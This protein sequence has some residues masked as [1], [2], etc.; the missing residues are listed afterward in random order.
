L[1]FFG[2]KWVLRVKELSRKKIGAILRRVKFSAR[3]F[4]N[5][6][7][8]ILAVV[9]FFAGQLPAASKTPKAA[10][11]LSDRFELLPLTRSWQ[12]QL[13]VRAR[14]NG[15][16]AVLMVDSGAPATLISLKR[17]SD[18]HL[19]GVAANSGLP[20]S[21]LVNG[22]A[23]KLAIVHSLRLGALNIV[24]MPV[25]LTDVGSPQRVAKMVREEAI[26]GILG[27]DVLFAT[28]AVMDCQ[29]QVLIL[30]RYP[31]VGGIENA[32]DLRGYHKTPIFVSEGYNLFVNSSINGTRTKL[33]V[34][35]GAVVTTLHLP[36]VRQL[37]I[38]HYE[39]SITSSGVNRREDA[40]QVARVQ[41]LS[42]GSVDVFG[43]AIGVADLRWLLPESRSPKAHPVGG[44]LGAELLKSHHGIIDFGSRTLYLKG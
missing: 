13:L 11:P 34:D 21:V 29:D 1:R 32:L 15:K 9:L 17:R 31:E 3:G 40:V 18:F 44:L 30:N 35:T 10:P 38:P 26:D 36:F 4:G 7:W 25:V 23:D 20:T 33:L 28:K 41:K 2:A 19:E 42:V 43:K 39:T 27:V 5:A 22:V 37:R 6:A 8:S 24:D 14:I 16:P 12:N